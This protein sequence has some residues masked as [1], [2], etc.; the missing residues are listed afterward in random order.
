MVVKS[1]RTDQLN[2]LIEI[3]KNPSLNVASEKLHISYQA[4]SHSMKALEQELNLTLLMRTN[5]GT[6]LTQE[7]LE[8]VTLAKD[9]I[10][11]LNRLTSPTEKLAGLNGTIRFLS[12]S[13]CMEY[14][15][16]DLFCELYQKAPQLKLN[17]QVAH[18]QQL[19]DLLQDPSLFAFSF[20]S[21]DLSLV[22]TVFPQDDLI[23]H[24]VFTSRCS[25]ICSAKHEL[26]RLHSVTLQQL[27]HYKYV[28]RAQEQ[29]N[30]KLFLPE[31]IIYEPNPIIYN[32]LISSGAC[33][34]FSLSIPFPPYQIPATEYTVTIP[35]ADDLLSQFSL[36]HHH[37]FRMTPTIKLFLRL[38]LDHM[39]LPQ[40]IL[41]E[42]AKNDEP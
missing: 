42:N 36:V 11:G 22:P 39:N 16:S 12:T 6:V 27:R 26:A 25:C 24:P 2:Y 1:V 7:G 10:K 8:L 33:F 38:L 34:S 5:K 9:F 31:N 13:I 32:K 18:S 28:V 17:C 4:L 30:T 20:I 19:Y 15:L 21:N 14:F 40:D 29:L 35:L 37:H 3:S 23:F 41:L